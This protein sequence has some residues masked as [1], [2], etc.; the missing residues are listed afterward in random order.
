[1]AV[2][3]NGFVTIHRKIMQWEWYT[4]GNTMRLFVHLLLLANHRDTKWRGEVIR[5]GQVLTGLDKLSKELGL[6][7]KKIRVALEHLIS[8]SEVANRSTN[9]YRVITINNYASYQDKKECK[10]Q[11]EGQAKGQSK[12]NQ[13]AASNNDNNDNKNTLSY[14]REARQLKKASFSPPSLEES[15]DHFASKG[16]PVTEAEKFWHH[17]NSNG[18]KV[19]GKAPMRSWESAAHNWMKNAKTY[20]GHNGAGINGYRNGTLA[21][22][23]PLTPECLPGIMQRI[24][25]DPRYT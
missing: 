10:G 3:D 14:E 16:W 6:S 23:Q 12:G 25:D 21:H 5:R 22:Q 13:R 20:G 17:F 1:M 24:A 2:N 8:T 18:W 4:D 9:K 19:G 15:V 7:V 11:A